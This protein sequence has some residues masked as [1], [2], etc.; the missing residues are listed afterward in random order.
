M[1]MLLKSIMFMIKPLL[2]D[3]TDCGA[4]SSPTRSPHR[5]K[6]RRR[7]TNQP[8]LNLEPSLIGKQSAMSDDWPWAL[9]PWQSIKRDWPWALTRWRPISHDSTLSPH[10][11]TVAKCYW[12]Y[13]SDHRSK[14]FHTSTSRH[15]NWQGR[16]F[17]EQFGGCLKS[18]YLF[19]FFFLLKE[20]LLQQQQ[21]NNN[22]NCF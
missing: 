7:R 9:T 11:L 12:P 1:L 3:N 2:T 19:L 18:F 6:K 16:M 22:K 20:T 14:S 8:W 5:K 15:F 17:L 21:K 10:S 13:S 4:N